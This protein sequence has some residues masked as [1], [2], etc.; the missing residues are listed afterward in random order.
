M[1]LLDEKTVLSSLHQSIPFLFPPFLEAIRRALL[2]KQ[3]QV[4]TTLLPCQT[5]PGKDQ[6][7]KEGPLK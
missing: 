1:P 4:T 5:Y 7:A 3:I 6:Q 2:G